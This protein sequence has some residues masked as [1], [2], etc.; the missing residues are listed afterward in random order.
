MASRTIHGRYRI[1][2]EIGRGAMGAVYRVWDASTRRQ[3]ALKT[4]RPIE[5]SEARRHRAELWFRREFHVV[6][7]LRHPCIVLVHDY[8]VDHETP[9]Y[10]ME[11]LDGQDLRDHP[12]FDVEAGCR[13]LRD[14]AS[15]L[16]FLHA[17]RLVHRDLKPRNVRCTARGRAK[18]IDFGILASMGSV[19]D[20]AGTPPSMA[21]ESVRGLPLD[22]R[23]D[24]FGLGTL[25]YWMFTGRHAFPV[26]AVDEL[27]QAWRTEP[28]PLRRLRD[29]VPAALEELVRSLIARDAGARPSSAAE[30]I[31]RIDAICGFIPDQEIEVAR[32]WLLSGAIVGRDAELAQLRADID[33]ATRGS[34]G[35]V[36]IEAPS[37]VGKSRLLK[38]AGWCGQIAG[39]LVL[40]ARAETAAA[41]PYAVVRQLVRQLFAQDPLLAERTAHEHMA[42]VGRILPHAG[43]SSDSWP[44]SPGTQAHDPA[45]ERLRLQ[46]EVLRYF[47]DVA[48]ERPLVLLVDEL[49]QCDEASAAFAAAL[50]H[51]GEHTPVVLVA[52]L[53]TDAPALAPAAIAALREVAARLV[54]EGL[55]LVG[56]RALVDALF[57]EL[58]GGD[59]LAVWL[60]QVARGN[61]MHTMELVRGLVD[62]GVL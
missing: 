47:E 21:P 24:L 45:E 12:Q 7:G 62:R 61:P 46:I 27:E 57:G 16:A 1:D 49:Q 2:E 11:L 52:A 5:E 48:R 29:D 33:A 35:A 9:Y 58:V 19:G 3:L 6:A 28:T 17:R 14:V 25:A 37:G 54:L 20:I 44:W 18:L 4:L 36:L 42:L 56:V 55:D 39:A 34:G 43:G 10:T 30:V 32:G 50:A 51:E 40:R 38:E 26:R 59:R 23:A 15:G 8:G 60:H 53:R 13:V 41:E 31:D 22:G